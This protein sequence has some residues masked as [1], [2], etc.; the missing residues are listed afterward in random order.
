M[1]S[2]D[3][4]VI[5][6][7]AGGIEALKALAR[8]LPADLNA[9]LFV[10]LHMGADGLPILPQILERAG[11]L[12][13]ANARD[14]EAIRP[15]HI[16]VA[17]PDH[18]LLLEPSGRVRL[19]RGP[20]E[21]RF[22]PAVDSLFRSAAHAF[23]PRVIG[24]VLTGFLDD[25]TAGLWAI[26]ARGGTAVVQNPE[27]ALAPSMPRSALAHVAVDHC[28]SLKDMA[29]LLAQ[30]ARTPVTEKGDPPVPRRMETEVN[31]AKQ[32]NALESGILDWGDPSLY[33]CPECHGVLLE[34]KEGSNLRFR[35][36]TGHA[37][38]LEALRAAFSERIE[39]SLWGAI[40]SLEEAE[41]LLRRTAAQAAGHGHGQA[42]AALDQQ[43]REAQRRADLVRRA[44]MPH[45]TLGTQGGA[46]GGEKPYP[47][48]GREGAVIA[49]LKPR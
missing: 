48:T 2:K 44:V 23:G 3:L 24:V 11:P 29:P 6:A 15:G 16:H 45:E 7:S 13:A 49:D 22:R 33:A 30:L 4:I 46:P 20:K 43:A 32:A 25:G 1:L 34:F 12:P 28:V 8:G 31:I 17:P 26:K 21:N 27:E 41:L 35:C 5:G 9:A 37:Y 42:A 10:V 19:S 14:G 47:A 38:S 36:H 39:G 40:R 18:H